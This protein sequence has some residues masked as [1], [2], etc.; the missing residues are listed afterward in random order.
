MRAA[1]E[2][3]SHTSAA[4]NS[5]PAAVDSPRGNSPRATGTS[6]AS[7]AGTANRNVD[8]SEIELIYPGE[9]DDAPTRRRHL[10]P[11]DNPGRTLQEPG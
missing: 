4:S 3:T 7:V 1:G 5:S 8:E 2:S 10:T 11:P 6:A 9:S